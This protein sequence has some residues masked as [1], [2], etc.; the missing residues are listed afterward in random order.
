MATGHMGD[1]IGINGTPAYVVGDR[2]LVGAAPVA[3][4]R[5]G[6]LP[7]LREKKAAGSADPARS[8]HACGAY[9]Y[10]TASPTP[11]KIGDLALL[12]KVVITDFIHKM[13]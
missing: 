10:G 7:K 8:P 3:G 1:A 13:G 6:E 5:S 11:H 2:V 12:P 4:D 9:V